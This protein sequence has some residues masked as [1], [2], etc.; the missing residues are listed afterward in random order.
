VFLRCRE[1]TEALAIKSTEHARRLYAMCSK[2]LLIQCK[3]F[4]NK[5]TPWNAEWREI[6]RTRNC[7]ITICNTA[8]KQRIALNCRSISWTQVQEKQQ[9]ALVRL[10]EEAFTTSKGRWR[11]YL[12]L[13]RDEMKEGKQVQEGPSSLSRRPLRDKMSHQHLSLLFLFIPLLNRY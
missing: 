4:K 3:M 1:I 13:G 7:T 12:A 10:Q 8:T 2:S 9:I 6:M 11:S 5:L